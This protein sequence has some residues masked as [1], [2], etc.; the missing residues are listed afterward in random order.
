MTNLFVFLLI[1][2]V[3]L[4]CAKYCNKSIMINSVYC[5]LWVPWQVFKSYMLYFVAHHLL[6]ASKAPKVHVKIQWGSSGLPKPILSAMACRCSSKSSKRPAA[7]F[8]PTRKGHHTMS[9]NEVR[10]QTK[11]I[12]THR[13]VSQ[14]S[15][16]HN[17]DHDIIL[18]L[19]GIVWFALIVSACLTVK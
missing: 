12:P 8:A 2:T 10:W 19:V 17:F 15:Y 5:T 7:L 14:H 1:C 9:R 3:K 18:L 6:T 13:M 16:Q 11:A 4:H